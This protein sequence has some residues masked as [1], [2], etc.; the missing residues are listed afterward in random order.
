MLIEEYFLLTKFV[1]L[2]YLRCSKYANLTFWRTII[3]CN[4]FQLPVSIGTAWRRW[5]ADYKTQGLSDAFTWSTATIALSVYRTM[6]VMTLFCWWLLNDVWTTSTAAVRLFARWLLNHYL[7]SQ[8]D[9]FF[10]QR[11]FLRLSFSLRLRHSQSTAS[12][13]AI[14]FLL[15]I[16]IYADN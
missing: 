14:E 10:C 4:L 12:V 13:E 8:N 16:Y 5:T 6:S 2:S 9:R 15:Y 3:T 1:N 7:L 11:F